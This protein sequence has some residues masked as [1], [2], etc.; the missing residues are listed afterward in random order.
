MM[1]FKNLS[2][3]LFVILSANTALAFIEPPTAISPT[4]DAV[5]NAASTVKSFIKKARTEVDAVQ[6]EMSNTLNQIESLKNY[7]PLDFSESPLQKA[8][9]GPVNSA[10]KKIVPS[11][12]VDL[13]NPQAV[14][15]KVKGLMVEY[16]E[17]IQNAPDD[18]KEYAKTQYQKKREEFANDAVMEVKVSTEALQNGRLKMLEEELKSLEDCYVLGKDNASASCQSASSADEELG[19]YANYY[20]L[21]AMKNSYMRMN[22]ELSALETQMDAALTLMEVEPAEAPD[23]SEAQK[24]SKKINLEALKAAGFGQMAKM[25]QDFALVDAPEYKQHTPFEGAEDQIRALP[26]FE[27]IYQLLSQAQTLHNV[28]QQLPQMRK[29]F[30]EYEKM[31]ALHDVAISKLA[32]SE[33]NVR[34]YFSS[35][36]THTDADDMWFGKGCKYNKVYV[37]KKCPTITG[38]KTPAD[39]DD[40]YVYSIACADD[41]F[42][43]N[44][45][46]KKRG[47]SGYVN[48]IY[49]LSKAQQVLELNQDSL[50]LPIIASNA[51]ADIPSVDED[52]KEKATEIIG[53]LD[54]LNDSS[55]NDYA[56]Q[57]LRAQDINRFQIGAY[58]ARYIGEDMKSSKPQFAKPKQPYR[59]YVDEKLF[60]DQYLKEKYKNMALYF[61]TSKAHSSVFAL[62]Q[63]INDLMQIDP[64]AIEA[65]ANSIPSDDE[66]RQAKINAFKQELEKKLRQVQRENKI[67]IQKAHDNYM[68]EHNDCDTAFSDGGQNCK[69]SDLL[70]T[71]RE[72][73]KKMDALI[74]SFEKKQ[75]TFDAQKQDVFAD[76]DEKRIQLNEKK[77]LFNDLMN[78]KQN[79]AANVDFQDKT[80]EIVQQKKQKDPAFINRT[81][82]R[83]QNEKQ[84]KQASIL[85]IDTQAEDVLQETDVGEDDMRLLE[86]KVENINEAEVKEKEAYI[87]KAAALEGAYF[88]KMRTLLDAR[89]E[90]LEMLK[91]HF[92]GD[93]L[94]LKAVFDTADALLSSFVEQAIAAVNNAY[95]KIEALD[96]DKYL[97]SKYNKI[98]KIH[99]QMLDEIKQIKVKATIQSVGGLLVG[100]ASVLK[101]AGNLI[102][103]AMFDK[104]CG[105]VSCAKEDTVYFV[106][107]DSSVRDFTA[108]KR[109][110]AQ[111]QPP[112][113]EVLH[114]DATDFDGINKAQNKTTEIMNIKIETLPVTTRHEFLKGL[115]NVPSIWQVILGKNG[116]VQRDV[117]I[118]EIL[119]TDD[120]NATPEENLIQKAMQQAKE[121]EFLKAKGEKP[122]RLPKGE[123]SLFLKFDNTLVFTDSIYNLVSF[124]DKEDDL[125]EDEVTEYRH[126]LFERNQIGDY[127]KFVD[128]EQ[129]YRTSVDQLKV[130]IDE[131][132]AQIENALKDVY[133]PY[134]QK[135]VGYLT[136]G[137]LKTKIV[138]SEFIADDETYMAIS[139][140][141]DEGKN[142]FLQEALM[143]Q[144]TLPVDLSQGL[145]DRKEKIDRLRK[146]LEMDNEELV[147]V[148]D[149]TEPNAAFNEQIITKRTDAAVT[150]RYQQE[151][152]SEFEKQLEAFETPYRAHYFD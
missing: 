114:F 111:R 78:E 139:K 83:A 49:K 64:K 129:S 29:P 93:D 43:M 32:E 16:P 18:V 40:Y 68:K 10:M 109:C 3:Y 108:P 28:K 98:L 102:Y 44:D 12:T 36:Y 56:D 140:C 137:E 149:N 136:E 57:E 23:T 13:T 143:L 15:D 9:D 41:V 100:D 50:N 60:Y 79:A 130:K 33:E 142:M 122:A 14:A 25:Q 6:T 106:S 38:C 62:A 81:E 2:V 5:N 59:L 65:F 30:L 54:N 86:N 116:F 71:K 123:L 87:K 103:A 37:G 107:L 61:A 48:S 20:K 47:F 91:P 90:N 19:N 135:E 113:R 101:T 55:T 67:G 39:Y 24:K 120:Q 99:E 34:D 119:N 75:K 17:A 134:T 92:L 110:S 124:F 76:I 26:I 144:S 11:K 1:L 150:D 46:T 8:E 4:M 117:D 152:Q 63:K 145:L 21:Q 127:L 146:V 27:G 52:P 112:I 138:S 121:D 31:K 45:F 74:N 69:V 141:L 97:P 126:R 82:S 125:D 85:D 7:I 94:Y 131:A 105:D 73:D 22:E 115:N 133:C 66:Q 51:S 53:N 89:K 151:A 118:L 77:T 42:Y 80:I 70:A 35:Y 147:S 104:G 132:K 95:G 96:N 148:S 128:L 72:F 88:K 84:E 58:A